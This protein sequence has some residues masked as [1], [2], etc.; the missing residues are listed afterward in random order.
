M[1]EVV[2]YA[3]QKLRFDLVFQRYPIFFG[4]RSFVTHSKELVTCT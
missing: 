3:P 2:R 4:N 1:H